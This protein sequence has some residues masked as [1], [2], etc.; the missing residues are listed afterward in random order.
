MATEKKDKQEA[1]TT[2]EY[3]NERVDLMIPRDPSNPK[4]GDVS[5]IVNGKIFQIKRG[6]TVQVP[7]YVYQAYMDSELQKTVA[8]DQQTQAPNRE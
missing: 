2:A 4:E 1:A 7:R 5:I 8:Y 3:W 6:V